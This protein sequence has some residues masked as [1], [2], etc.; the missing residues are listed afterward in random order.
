MVVIGAGDEIIVRFEMPADEPPSGWKRDFI[1]HSVGW[2]KDADLNTL[3]G[4]SI[5]PL[6]YRGMQQYP[7]VEGLKGGLKRSI[8]S[9]VIICLDRNH[10]GHFGIAA[11]KLSRFLNNRRVELMN[12]YCWRLLRGDGVIQ[13][14]ISAGFKKS[15]QV[16]CEQT[17]CRVRLHR[18]SD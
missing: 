12:R 17:I 7:P 8:S 9:I 4:Q 11:T 13:N 5:G 6:P 18:W 14:A 10:L 3:A 1:I 16:F 15:R 2:D